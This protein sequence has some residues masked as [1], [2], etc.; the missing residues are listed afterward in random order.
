MNRQR[1]V[2]WCALV[3]LC[4]AVVAG[5]SLFAPLSPYLGRLLKA[6]D[7]GHLTEE[8][9][10]RYGT[11]AFTLKPDG[12]YEA[13]V[14][15]YEDDGQDADG[16]GVLAEGWVVVDGSRG[17]YSWDDEWCIME[18]TEESQVVDGEWVAVADERTF[19]RGYYFTEQTF[20]VA[21]RPLDDPNAVFD[22]FTVTYPD[23]TSEYEEINLMW[24]DNTQTTMTITEKY[25]DKDADGNVIDGEETTR[26]GSFVV[27]PE[28]TKIKQGNAFTFRVTVTGTDYPDGSHSTDQY[29]RS[30]DFF[31]AGRFYVEWLE[32]TA[33]RGLL[34]P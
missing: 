6:D 3:A 4:V 16:D 18:W 28:G 27:Y 17:S 15:S 5:C 21:W 30:Y 2:C 9:T 19:T 32:P 24:G 13:T 31:H 11:S 1:I 29:I 10:Y 12:T 33:Q 20:G 26:N 23:G 34:V 14:E 8:V 22:G 25:E 7:D